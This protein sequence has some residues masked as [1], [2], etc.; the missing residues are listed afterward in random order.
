MSVLSVPQT[1]NTKIHPH[2]LLMYIAIGSMT[3]MF[4]GWISAY[5]VREGQGRWE[6]IQLPMAFYISTAVILLSSVTVHLAA[7][8]HKKKNMGQYKGMLIATIVLGL[9]F[10]LFQ[11]L[12]FSTMY[13]EMDIKLNANNAA[14]EFTY[15]IPFVHG[16]HAVG[17]IVALI[18]VFL[19]NLVRSKKGVYKS[20]GIEIASI[21]WHFV[22]ALWLFI[23]IFLLV[24]QS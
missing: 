4:A 19:V 1:E 10:I 24:Y 16:V 2:K 3:M 5:M 18:M 22:D 12:G 21:F 7:S 15:V 17:G 6:D 8:A 13:N 14:G 20:M 23:F 11:V 9:L